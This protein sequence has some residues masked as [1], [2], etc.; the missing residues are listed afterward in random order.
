MSTKPN[1]HYNYSSMQKL[2]KCLINRNRNSSN[3]R[4]CKY[5][6]MGHSHLRF[7]Q[8]LHEPEL[9]IEQW[10]TLYYMDAFTPVI[11]STIAWT[12]K[13]NNGLCTHFLRLRGLKTSR[14]SSCLNNRRCEL[15][16]TQRLTTIPRGSK[17]MILCAA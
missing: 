16:L 15:S 5:N 8:L 4:R 17:E 12:E 6:L 7:S 13:L 1:L 9:I 11:S 10:V 14:N 2:S 3:N